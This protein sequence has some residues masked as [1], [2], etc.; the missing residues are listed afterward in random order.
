MRIV[1]AGGGTGGHLFPGVAVAEEL[2]RRCAETAI[3]FVGTERGLE[4]KVLGA[5]G[6]PLST[7][8]I[9][10]IKGRGLMRACRALAK[11]PGSLC[12]SLHLVRSFRPD[13]VLGVGGYASGP[14]VLAA[15]ILG[16]KTAIAEQNALPGLTNR[17][18]GHIVDMIFVTF[19]ETAAY[20]PD[21]R[22]Q[23]T[24]NPIRRAFACAGAV[25]PSQEGT[26]DF[27]ILV[28][29][30]SQGAQAL[31]R[32][33]PAAL[34]EL[35]EIAARL[36]IVHQAGER[37]YEHVRAQYSAA[38]VRAEVLPFIMDM[39]TRFAWADLL[40][41]R[42]GATTIAEITAGGKAAILIPF[43]YAVA[44]HQRKNAEVLTRA[45]AAILIPECDLNGSSLAQAILELARDP[46]RLRQMA[47]RARSLGHPQAAAT[48]ADACTALAGKD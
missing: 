17:L 38:G 7:L 20:F 23:V 1:I 27:H 45:G 24:G 35:A 15:R 31:N 2:R 22:V 8:D 33:V 26:T 46:L 39:A 41:C 34:P 6:F 3:L 32:A 44:D 37:D 16:V 25:A 48:I 30:G 40:I 13:V 14:A 42:A 47:E 36:V 12:Q 5:L 10:G 29:G 11:L 9:E 28:F 18:L 4:K 19:P 43:P 21:R